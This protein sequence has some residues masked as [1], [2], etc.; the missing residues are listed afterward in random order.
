MST[1]TKLEHDSLSGARTPVA[2]QGILIVRFAEVVRVMANVKSVSVYGE[3]VISRVRLSPGSRE[4]LWWEG[5]EGKGGVGVREGAR[6][7]AKKCAR[8]ESEYVHSNVISGVRLSPV[9]SEHL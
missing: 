3:N 1:I 2:V 5:V 7:S 4:H 6:E 9:C 8:G